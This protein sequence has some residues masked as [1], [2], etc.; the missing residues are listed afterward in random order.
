MLLSGT[1]PIM[2]SAA[3]SAWPK[4]YNPHI[5]DKLDRHEPVD[6]LVL[7]DDAIEQNAET[8]EEEG[9][10][11]LFQ[12]R[13]SEYQHRVQKRINRMR[14]LKTTVTFEVDDTGLEVMTEYP[15]LP[16]IHMR[17]RSTKALD[18]LSSH[19]KV[20]SIDE[21]KP[22][23]KFLA[24]SLP[25]IERANAQMSNYNGQNVT[26][27]V[28]DT[29]VNYTHTA[30]GS[31]SAPGGNCKVVY[32]QDFATTDNALDD[33]GH[34][35]NVA[36][37][38]LGVAP[39]AKI[40]ALDVFRNDGFAYTSDLVNAI[41]WCVTNKAAYNIVALNMSLGS[42]KY[43]SPVSPIDS[44][45][46]AIQRA[47]DA[48]ILVAAAS[49]NS[50]YTN[51]LSIP[52]AYSNVVSVG[53]VYDSNLGG[54]NWSICSDSSTVADKVTCF[55][56]SASFLTMLAP[57]S[58]ITA[59]GITMSGTSQATPHVAGAAAVFRA[60][61]PNDSV[62]QTIARL[63]QG[64]TVTD[65]RNGLA[66]PRL[67]LTAANGTTSSYAL[68]ASVTPNGAG[69]VTPASGVYTPGTSVSL[70]VTANSGY[71]F[72]GWSG[73][74]SGTVTTCHLLMDSNKTVTAGF[75]AVPIPLISGVTVN[76]LFDSTD[77]L[78]HFYIDIPTGMSN[79]TIKTSGG[80]GDVDLYVRRDNLPTTGSYDCAPDLTGNAETCT[81]TNPSAGRYY[82][83]LYAYAA[84]SG[85]SLQASFSTALA[86]QTVQM[87]AA[88]Y[89]I[90]EGGGSISIPVFR[91]GGTGGSVTV[92]YATTN[93]TAR[94]RSDY[95]SKSGT[96]SWGEG[97]SSIRTITI[98]IINNTTKEN[99]EIFS[100]RLSSA[101]GAIL[102]ANKTATVTIIDN[103]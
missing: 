97:D 85:V 58:K 57:G 18:K 78:K 29:G 72:A 48:G 98:P 25:L 37:T 3:P 32:A 91:E 43:T 31:C 46:T 23:Q 88:S 71:S 53:A 42:G 16:I 14:N 17:I 77:N 92:K 79:L 47:V 102:G 35:T 19:G 8:R 50:G 26:V 73:D 63:R 33:D 60:A 101:T 87:S 30:F 11:S 89:S 27:A 67:S 86:T 2:A 28:L 81:F 62:T 74:C 83:S 52:S 44:W 36:A 22:H 100:L 59:G 90:S 103:D 45:G 39:S 24:Q 6:V 34:G 68:A 93:G 49:G 84:Y 10:S 55:S 38:V 76:N 15:A 40:A 65:S 5:A 12:A 66:T 94:S 70:T 61:Y 96:L 13:G 41:N 82:A 64:A 9:K 1:L 21:N 75:A 95:S 56:N 69:L 7:L 20:L 4:Q 51:G 54:L 99:S 80:T